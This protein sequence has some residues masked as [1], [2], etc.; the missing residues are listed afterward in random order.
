M[1]E[2]IRFV[3]RPLDGE[4][5]TGNWI[6]TPDYWRCHVHETLRKVCMIRCH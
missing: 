3:A 2:R 6:C 1:D 4:S 5:E